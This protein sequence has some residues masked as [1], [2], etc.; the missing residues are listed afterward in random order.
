MALRTSLLALSLLF[1]SAYAEEVILPGT[2]TTY[3]RTDTGEWCLTARVTD[4]EGDESGPSNTVCK[5]A[6]AT[7]EWTPPTLNV[8]GSPVSELTSYRLTFEEVVPPPVTAPGP[9]RLLEIGTWSYALVPPPPPPPPPG[10][11]VYEF[12]PATVT[13][14][15]PAGDFNLNGTFTIETT[16]TKTGGAS[17]ARIISKHR[18]GSAAAEN[19]TFMLSVFANN[20][21]R[22]RLWTDA[23]FIEVM[24]TGGTIQTGIEQT[25]RMTY[26]GSNV[27]LYANG[28]LDVCQP[29]TGVPLVEPHAVTVG[30]NADG[31]AQFQGEIY[32]RIQ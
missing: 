28:V 1:S 12:G 19:H 26:D 22:G 20:R 32:V 7:W 11:L 6:P 25:A 23:G 30:A 9:V 18:G 17:D 31:Y 21:M 3:E 4:I 24:G 15:E 16:F 10:L 27:C 29:H 8:D 2:A 14:P 5:N 13:G